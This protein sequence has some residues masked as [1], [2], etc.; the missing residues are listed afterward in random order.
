MEFVIHIY[1][2]ELGGR[3]FIYTN[4]SNSHSNP[5][6]WELLLFSIKDKK[7]KMH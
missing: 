3:H 4:T 6:S 5:V 2:H 7:I 1:E